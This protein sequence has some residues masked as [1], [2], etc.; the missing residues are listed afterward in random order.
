MPLAA[1]LYRRRLL[2]AIA[3]ALG[4]A[5]LFFAHGYNPLKPT[6][7]G[8]GAAIWSLPR[9]LAQG[10]DARGIGPMVALLD[11]EVPWDAHLGVRLGRNAR[12]YPLY[13]PE[14]DRKLIPL[15]ESDV[16]EAAE[17][18]RLDWVFL[19]IEQQV[20]PL[21]ECWERIDLAGT[22]TLLRRLTDPAC[23]AGRFSP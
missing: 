18:A 5:T 15:P 10:L 13:G 21:G 9:P 2:A 17:A 6:G 7:L 20:P 12:G 14:L 3:A 19:G 4:A 8:G 23:D 11:A 1:V 22:A 16:I